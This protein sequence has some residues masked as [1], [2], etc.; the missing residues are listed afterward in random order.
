M[1]LNGYS[2]VFAVVL[3]TGRRLADHFGRKKLFLLGVA[4]FTLS[5]MLCGIAANPWL[6]ITFRAVQVA[7]GALLLPS[8]LAL[9]LDSFPKSRRAIAVT[10]WGP[11]GGLA[12]GNRPLARRGYHPAF[13]LAVGI[14]SECSCW[15]CGVCCRKNAIAESRDESARRIPEFSGIALSIGA[16]ASLT[17]GI[18]RCE[19]ASWMDVKVVA[20]ICEACSV[21]PSFCGIRQSRHLRFL[22]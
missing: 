1:V 20:T 17:Y 22:I 3:L 6:L 7:G 9:V 16:M 8:S 2:I 11:I 19:V 18:I 21:S 10:T 14:L 15:S 12:T 4:I 5:S 13:R